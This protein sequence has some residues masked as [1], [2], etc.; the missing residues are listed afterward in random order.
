MLAEAGAKAVE[1][2]RNG[3]DPVKG[4]ALPYRAQLSFLP[5]PRDRAGPDNHTGIIIF[6]SIK[7]PF[8]FLEFIEIM[9]IKGPNHS[10]FSMYVNF[11]YTSPSELGLQAEPMGRKV[12]GNFPLTSSLGKKALL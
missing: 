6:S 9:H 1:T 8:F 3:E 5:G 4:R 7:L 12:G 11:Y 2:G 10:K